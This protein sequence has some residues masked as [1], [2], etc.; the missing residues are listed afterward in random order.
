VKPGDV[1]WTR[2]ATEW[3]RVVID[4]VYLPDRLVAVHAL[5]PGDSLARVW[6]VPCDMIR[7]EE[8]SFDELDADY[9]SG[10]YEFA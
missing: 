2:I 6:S 9:G 5:F 7:T 4:Y 3:I 1:V 10:E 8:P